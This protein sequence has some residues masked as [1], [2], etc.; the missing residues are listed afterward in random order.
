M[1]EATKKLIFWLESEHSR[2]MNFENDAIKALDNSDNE[3]YLKNIKK[4]A[5]ALAEIYSNSEN[6]LVNVPANIADITRNTLSNFSGNAKMSLK[7]NSPFFMSA[8][9]YPDE[10]KKGEPDNFAIF[11]KDLKQEF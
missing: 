7:I 8:L 3:T 2:I 5:E 1:D 10:H 4:K 11:I 6:Y 9:L